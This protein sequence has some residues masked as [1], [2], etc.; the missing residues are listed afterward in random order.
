MSLRLA[1]LASGITVVTDPMPHLKTAAVGIWVGAGSRHETPAEHGISHL[2]EH[3]AFKGTK[4]RSARQISEE[5]ETVGGDL[6]AAA[7]HETTGYFARV[8]GENVALALD[9]LTDI[10][11]EPA[12]DKA[13]LKREQ[14]VIVQEIGAAADTP[15]DLVFDFFQ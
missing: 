8:L 13:E 2:L 12:F 1:K 9:I 3:M 5:I 11:T 6:N 4:R 7:S 14:G 15:D 10:L